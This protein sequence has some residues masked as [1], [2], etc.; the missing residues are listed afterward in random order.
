MNS[1]VRA[2]AAWLLVATTVAYALAGVLWY[3]SRGTFGNEWLVASIAVY[4]SILLGAILL[5][6]LDSG[7]TETRVERIVP[8]ASPAGEPQLLDR[9]VI[10]R[11]ADGMAMRLTYLW[12]D[13]TRETR[14]AAFT[15]G[16]VLTLHE[17]ETHLDAL[18]DAPLPDDFDT[19]TARALARHANTPASPM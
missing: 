11:T 15:P 13:G 10:Y 1:K 7:T 5:A 19:L 12:P 2:R 18:A 6:V 3:L 17:I 14:L 9:E 16:E 8:V 4:G